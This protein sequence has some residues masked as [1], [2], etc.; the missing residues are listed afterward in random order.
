MK[1]LEMNMYLDE[2]QRSHWPSHDVVFFHAKE[3]KLY[4]TNALSKFCEEFGLSLTKMSALA[5]GRINSHKGLTV[6][7]HGEPEVATTTHFI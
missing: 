6:W 1:K 7:K 4:K 5:N 3:F 2:T